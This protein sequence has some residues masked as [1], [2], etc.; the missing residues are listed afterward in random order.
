ML[1]LIETN[2]KQLTNKCLALDGHNVIVSVFLWEAQLDVAKSLK[3]DIWKRMK[4]NT[5][6]KKIFNEVSLLKHYICL[7]LISRFRIH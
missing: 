2:V 7:C 1:C 5:E 4:E 6:N 3:Q